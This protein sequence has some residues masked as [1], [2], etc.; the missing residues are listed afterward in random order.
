MNQSLAE[1]KFR[2]CQKCG[3]EANTA[4]TKCPNCGKPLL[5]QTRLRTLGA[6]QL[7]CGVFLVVMMAVV[8]SNLY[9]TLT[10]ARGAASGFTGTE[11]QAKQILALLG[12]VFAAGVSFSLAGIWQII[13]GRRSR[14]LVWISFLVILAVVI[15]SVIFIGG[16]KS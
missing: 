8:I 14:P 3:Y 5:T 16:M 7:I 12:L 9:P 2:V 11:T 15:V 13:Y 10:Q 6:I 1:T 4:E